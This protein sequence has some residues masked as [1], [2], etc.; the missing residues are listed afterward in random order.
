MTRASEP[1]DG[2]AAGSTTADAGNNVPDRT[3]GVGGVADRPDAV[4]APQAGAADSL[5]APS[6]PTADPVETSTVGG[7]DGAAGRH[8][9]P[10][11]APVPDARSGSD[12]AGRHAAPDGG[13]TATLAPTGNAATTTVATGTA[14]TAITTGGPPRTRVNGADHIDKPRRERRTISVI[15]LAPA[16][17]VL[18]VLV[19]WPIVDT[20]WYSF[21]DSNGQKF[22]G[23]HN[24]GTMFTDPTTRHAI[25]NNI[26]WVVVAP[27]LV[28]ILG[29]VFAVLTERIRLATAFKTILFVPMAISFLSAGVTWRLV[30]DSSPDRGALNAVVVAIHDTFAPSSEYPGARPRDTKVLIGAGKGNFQTA[31]SVNAGT[32]VVLPLVGIAPANLPTHDKQAVQASGSGVTGTVWLDFKLGGGGTT[33]AIDQ[34]E[35][36]LGG[37]TVQAVRNGKVLDTTKTA[38]DGTFHFANLTGSGYTLRLP[39]S[40]F[41]APY[42]GVNW[43]GPTFVTPAIIVS[44]LWVWAGFAMVLIAAGLAALPR[45]ALEA[46]R[47]DGATEWQVFRRVTIPLVRPVLIVVFVTLVINVLKTFDLIYV[48]SPSESLPHSTVVAVQMYQVAFGGVQ[49]SGL[50]SALGVLLFILVIPAMIFNLRRLR[51]DQT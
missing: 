39:A 16:L 21:H 7:T 11:G 36:G 5:A 2:A 40:N 24:Y 37:I 14:A 31:T 10:G 41:A 27:T 49:D 43:L 30:Y 26:I 3:G 20:V 45:D 8:R 46:A 15:F 38:D 33:N 13:A 50:G 35:R 6:H 9:G 18:A 51:R 47:V 25:T 4:T 44:Y 32:P 22:V 28:S 17:V 34:G 12:D 1:V 48:I 19:A 42:G 23:L 29:L